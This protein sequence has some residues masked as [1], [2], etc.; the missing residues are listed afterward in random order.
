[1]ED[2]LAYADATITI[3]DIDRL[4]H[5]AEDRRRTYAAQACVHLPDVIISTYDIDIITSQHAANFITDQKV[6]APAVHVTR[7]Q[8]AGSI[9]LAGRIVLTTNADPGFEYLFCRGIAG[10]VTQYG[11][12]ASHMSIRCMETGTPAAIGC[13]PD[14]FAHLS[15]AHT[16]TL[17]CAQQLI[18]PVG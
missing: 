3:H 1:M 8:P 14:T 9:D 16:I 11:G 17:D 15:R 2:L 13:G 12:M 18:T 10:L 5:L 4:R 7:S 6:T